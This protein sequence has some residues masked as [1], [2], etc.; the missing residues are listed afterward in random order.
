MPCP[1]V[2]LICALGCRLWRGKRYRYPSERDKPAEDKQQLHR[3]SL[4]K[5]LHEDCVVRY[6]LDSNNAGEINGND[7]SEMPATEPVGSEW[8]VT[9]KVKRRPVNDPRAPG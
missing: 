9:R 8:G 1:L 3:D 5:Q 7:V 6:G 2:L 4:L